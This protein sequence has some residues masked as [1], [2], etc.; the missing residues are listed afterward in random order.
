MPNR[1]IF[2]I[3]SKYI[4]YNLMFLFIH[5][6]FFTFYAA[7]ILACHLPLCSV[8]AACNFIVTL[9]GVAA[10]QR[11]K[12]IIFQRGRS[13]ISWFFSQCEMLFPGRKFLSLPFS[14]FHPSLFQFFFFP[15]P[16]SLF[17][18]IL[19][20]WYISRNFPVRSV[21]GAT[22]PSGCYTTATMAHHR[23]AS[24]ELK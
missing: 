1:I 20:S 10:I 13:H 23:A 2:I 9:S 4:S 12:R 3:I 22:C 6:F 5:L 24:V 14:I 21:W 15:S 16:F 19:F 11:R 17:S 18:L 8:N 7:F